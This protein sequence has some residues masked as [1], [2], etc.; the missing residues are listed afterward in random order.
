MNELN[1]GLSRTKKLMTKRSQK[2]LLKGLCQENFPKRGLET[3]NQIKRNVKITTQL[4]KTLKEG[5]NK[6]ANKKGSKNE[7]D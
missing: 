3:G 4:L 2:L 7:E 1:E 5:L 6:T